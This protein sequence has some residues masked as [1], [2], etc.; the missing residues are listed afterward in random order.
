MFRVLALI[1]LLSVAQPS[2]AGFISFCERLLGRS[3]DTYT[4]MKTEQIRRVWGGIEDFWRPWLEARGVKYYSSVL[5]LYDFAIQTKCGMLAGDIGPVYCVGDKNVYIDLKTI[6][7]FAKKYN[8]TGE[9]HL[10]AILAHEYGHHV[11]EL[12]GLN[13]KIEGLMKGPSK[14][15]VNVISSMT[16]L[17]MD[18]FS[19]F[20]MGHMRAK[21]MMKDKDLLRIL[22]APFSFG[23]DVRTFGKELPVDASCMNHATGLLREEWTTRGYAAENVDD[24]NAFEDEDMLKLLPESLRAAVKDVIKYP[25][26]IGTRRPQSEAPG[27]TQIC[28]RYLGTGVNGTYAPADPFTPLT[29]DQMDS[30]M[31]ELH[32]FWEPRLAERGVIFK[33]AK[34][35]YYTNRIKSKACGEILADKGPLYCPGDYNIYIDF[36]E[37]NRIARLYNWKGEG[38]TLYI[39]AHEYGHHVF[40]LMQLLPRALGL[41]KSVSKEHANLLNVLNELTTD[42]LAGFFIGHLYGRGNV[43]QTDLTH[44]EMTAWATGDD[45]LARSRYQSF[46]PECATHGTSMQR[47][48]WFKRGLEADYLEAINAF[49]DTSLTGQL[50]MNVLAEALDLIQYPP[51]KKN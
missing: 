28:E 24:F 44:M 8:W 23:S 34:L 22:E 33:R 43:N 48:Y 1:A 38:A 45:Y 30:V 46:N 37:L 32:R 25:V 20:F 2:Q 21:R 27:W 16:E 49:Y 42:G 36:K 29:E 51:V 7:R 12:M 39:L 35:I 15:Q 26:V 41:Q 47:K 40:Q 5:V 14:D 18:G 10:A 11:F 31:Q 9:G 6:D 50:P 17:T 4:P 13:K 3:A 19:G